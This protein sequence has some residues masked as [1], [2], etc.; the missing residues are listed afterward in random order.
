[1]HSDTPGIVSFP[2]SFR[3]ELLS[4]SQIESLKSGT[5]T[6]LEEVGVQFP[7]PQALEIFADHGAKVDMHKQ[8]VRIP[9]EL[10]TRA[11]ST[12]PRL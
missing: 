9:A 7:S 8:T 2:S 5:L 1:M 6:L 3:H 4:K 10:V 12:A 11:M